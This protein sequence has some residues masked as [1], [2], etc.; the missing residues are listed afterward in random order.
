MSE[1]WKRYGDAV[2][3]G[4]CVGLALGVRDGLAKRAAVRAEADRIAS[5]AM[6]G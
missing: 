5:E 6:G 1:W 2:I 4:A 3:I